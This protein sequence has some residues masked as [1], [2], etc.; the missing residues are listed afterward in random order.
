MFY[1]SLAFTGVTRA[2]KRVICI[3][4]KETLAHAVKTEG[5]RRMTGLAPFLI[6]TRREIA[7]AP[8]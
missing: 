4:D 5:I 8:G 2:K 3:G 1:R 6:E 7:L